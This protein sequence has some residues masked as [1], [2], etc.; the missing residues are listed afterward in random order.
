MKQTDVL[1]RAERRVASVGPFTVRSLA[2]GRMEVIPTW[3]DGLGGV[4][5]RMAV[6]ALLQTMLDR[7][8][9]RAYKRGRAR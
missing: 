9:A 1:S 6:A 3:P 4:I 7:L 8:M 5:N 2:D